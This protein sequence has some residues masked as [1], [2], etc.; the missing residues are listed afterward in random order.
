MIATERLQHLPVGKKPLL[1]RLGHGKTHR[2]RDI[3]NA[4]EVQVQQEVWVLCTKVV[5]HKQGAQE[6][7]TLNT[8]SLKGHAASWAGAQRFMPPS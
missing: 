2:K 8:G 3:P 7:E 6:Q 4:T 1:E 5:V